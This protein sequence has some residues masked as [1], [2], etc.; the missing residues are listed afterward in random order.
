MHFNVYDVF[1]S[2]NSYQHVLAAS[3]AIFRILCKNTVV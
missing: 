1:Y 3:A 2:L